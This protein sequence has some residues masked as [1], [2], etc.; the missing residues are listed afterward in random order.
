MKTLSEKL[1]AL[2]K[3]MEVLKFYHAMDRN[4]CMLDDLDERLSDD[5]IGFEIENLKEITEDWF[6]N[7]YIDS[8]DYKWVMTTLSECEFL[9]EL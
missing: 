6:D 2:N 1:E 8:D 7:G 9:G 3:L 5:S 4:S